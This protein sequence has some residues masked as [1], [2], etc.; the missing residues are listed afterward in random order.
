LVQSF[1]LLDGSEIAADLLE[2]WGPELRPLEVIRVLLL[3]WGR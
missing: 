1:P 2:V 3:L